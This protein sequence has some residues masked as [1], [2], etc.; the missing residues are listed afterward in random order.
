M[1]SDI[2]REVSLSI[3]PFSKRRASFLSVSFLAFKRRKEGGHYI[4]FFI[5]LGAI[6]WLFSQ[7]PWWSIF[8]FKLYMPSFFMY[9]ILPMFRAY[10]RFG[11]LVMFA[12]AVLAGFGLK[13][14]LERFKR[15]IVKN[16]VTV[17]ACCLALFEFWNYPPP[18]VIDVSKAPA[19]YYWLKNEPKDTVIAE[20]PLDTNGANDLYKFY[21]TKHEK[22]M[23]NGTTP[24]TYPNRIAAGI[25]KLSEIPT[26]EILRWMG[27]K[28]VFVHEDDYLNSGLT[29]DKD[30]FDKIAKNTG[31]KFIRTFPAENCSQK[32][33]MCTEKSGPI[34]V[35]EVVAKAKMP[36]VDK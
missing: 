8:G 25:T 15:P 17:F 24:G 6:A 7:P 35:Y 2:L 1:F 26:A 4:N 36:M 29:E 23:V 3:L 22:R 31:L 21:Q 11:I 16:T 18:K 13:F 27:A 32:D 34:H 12:I 30:E 10:C 19:V 14:F 28:Y 33:A 5:F 20:Y 9:K